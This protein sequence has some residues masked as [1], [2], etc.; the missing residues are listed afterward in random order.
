MSETNDIQSLVK[1]MDSLIESFQDFRNDISISIAE[2]KASIGQLQKEKVQLFEFHNEKVTPR[3]NDLSC[4]L[5][6]T[7]ELESRVKENES[8]DSERRENQIRMEER[9]AANARLWKTGGAVVAAIL[10][11]MQI[12]S[13]TNIS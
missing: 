13:M 9:Q 4:Y 2:C 8:K 5:K 6:K 3:L 7:D 12:L 11:F 10:A 1:K